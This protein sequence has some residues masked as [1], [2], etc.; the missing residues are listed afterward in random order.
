MKEITFRRDT[1]GMK[2]LAIFLA[3]VIKEGLTYEIDNAE[4]YVK[5]ELT[6]GY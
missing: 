4:L 1:E 6:G 2:N 5:V 3:Q